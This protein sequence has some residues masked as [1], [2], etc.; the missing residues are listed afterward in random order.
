METMLMVVM[1]VSALLTL[2]AVALAVGD[3]GP[4]RFSRA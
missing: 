3:D 1:F 2:A 4:D